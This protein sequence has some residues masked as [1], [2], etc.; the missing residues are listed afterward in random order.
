MSQEEWDKL[1]GDA[2]SYISMWR[3]H[4]KDFYS[5]KA[6]AGRAT[7]WVNR[8]RKT[9]RFL[10]ESAVQIQFINNMFDGTSVSGDSD[11][12]CDV[13][14]LPS[15]SKEPIVAINFSEKKIII[16]GTEYMGEIKKSVFT[17][18]NYVLTEV[19]IL[20]MHCSVNV[21]EQHKKPA[22][23]FGL[24]GTG[25]T[26]LSS[27]SDRVLLGD[28]EH[29]WCP[30]VIFNI[31]SG[32][33]AKTIGLSMETEPEIYKA[34]NKFGSIFENV[35]INNGE[36]DFDDD[37]ITK[38]GRVS[39]PLSSFGNYVK[40]GFVLEDPENIIM[41]TCDAFGVLPPVAKLTKD[42]AKEMFLVGYTSKVAG[43]EAGV[44]EPQ[45]VFSPCFGAPF[46][47]RPPE[48]YGRL[49]EKYVEENNVDC[50]LV[51]TGWTGG[52]YGVGDRMPLDQTRSIIQAILSGVLSSCKFYTHDQTGFII[53][54]SI[55]G[56]KDIQTFPE[57]TWVD[58]R[59]YESAAKDLM[60][61]IEAKVREL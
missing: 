50:W 44:T 57:K 49:L 35:I 30:G 28:D 25:K 53:P 21:D 40:P 22:I 32:C 10:C 41:L 33:Y 14:C 36:P 3:D 9:F 48:V 27:S 45:T 23:F 60:M 59:Q 51:N 18:M 38:N 12:E 11:V 55:P 46:L 19:G 5:V 52:G 17:Y 61:A 2:K 56:R 43:T 54:T 13:Y 26:T 58:K 20:P 1:L 24:S 37:S 42:K 39:Y 8:T 6:N 29:A 16:T 7:K 31:E 4:D 34:A 15:M 47:P